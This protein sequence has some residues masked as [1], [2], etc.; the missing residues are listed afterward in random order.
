VLLLDRQA[1]PV[2][3]ICAREV[4]VD[5]FSRLRRSL[6][7]ARAAGR[8]VGVASHNRGDGW[9]GFDTSEIEAMHRRLEAVVGSIDL[10]CV[11][12]VDAGGDCA[13]RE[14]S[15]GVIAAGAA[16]AGA[17][18]DACAVVTADGRL[19]R[20]A[21]QAGTATVVRPTGDDPAEAADAV[22]RSVEAAVG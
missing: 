1:E 11:C 18:V 13:C 20:A 19:R 5:D 8:R 21:E 4:P 3:S 9:E 10:W 2:R 12:L 16:A 6:D 22:A 17:T 14:P 7:Q 15:A